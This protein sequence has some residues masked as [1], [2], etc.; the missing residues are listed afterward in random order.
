MYSIF[1]LGF[2]YRS[3]LVCSS[4]LPALLAS[5]SSPIQVD[6]LFFYF[7]VER[8]LFYLSVLCIIACWCTDHFISIYWA[9]SAIPCVAASRSPALLHLFPAPGGLLALCL[10]K[11]HFSFLPVLSWCLNWIWW[12]KGGSGTKTKFSLMLSYIPGRVYVSRWI[13][14]DWVNVGVASWA[15]V[16]VLSEF[17]VGI[18]FFYSTMHFR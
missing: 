3:S 16:K 10:A 2:V 18:I 9:G 14:E 13:K 12:W 1:A 5:F 11:M 15:P 7:S 6:G 17:F 8:L 4:I